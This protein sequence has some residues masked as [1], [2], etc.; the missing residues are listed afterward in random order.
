MKRSVAVRT[1]IAAVVS[2]LSILAIVP[3]FGFLPGGSFVVAWKLALGLLFFAYPL[4]LFLGVPA[5]LLLSRFKLASI[6]AAAAVGFISAC[7]VPLVMLQR[8]SAINRRA[9]FFNELTFVVGLSRLIIPFALLGVLVGIA[10][11]LI[12]RVPAGSAKNLQPSRHQS[13]GAAARD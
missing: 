1:F 2:P 9:T 5:Y 10:F 12:A 7:I 4:T 13:E 8:M 6:W 3:A 11:W